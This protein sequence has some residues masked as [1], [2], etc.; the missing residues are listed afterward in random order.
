VSTR[1]TKSFNWPKVAKIGLMLAAITGSFTGIGKLMI[2]I[3]YLAGV[4]FTVA[5]IFKFK[6]HKDNPTQIPLGTPLALL[7]LGIV[8]VFLPGLFKPAGETVFGTGQ[9]TASA[10][11]PTGAGFTKIPGNQ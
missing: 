2:G 6:Q 7:V 9:A 8:L 3:A 5:A 10:G 4:G 11:G 1:L